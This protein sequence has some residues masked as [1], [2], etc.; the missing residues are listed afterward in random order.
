MN[1][2]ANLYRAGAAALTLTLA[3]TGLYAQSA[4]EPATARETATVTVDFAQSRGAWVHPERYNNIGRANYW[5]PQRDAD[6]RFFNANGLHGNTY[7]IFVI[8]N[9]L[10]DPATGKVDISSVDDWFNDVGRLSDNILMVLD[11]RVQLRDRH[12]TREQIRPFIKK[13]LLELKRKYP[14]I[15]YIEAFNEP[16]YNLA[17]VTT[18]SG[19]YDYYKDVYEIVNEVNRELKPAVP[20]QV[21]G[22]SLMM[23]ND[24]WMRAFLD[25]YKADPSPNKRLDFVSWHEYGEFPPGTAAAGGP[26]AF[27][28]YKTNPSEV[29]AHRIKFNEEMR[30]RGLK[31]DTPSFITETG[32]YPGP[33]SDHPND[34]RPD[35]LIGAAGIPSLHYWMLE[36][37]HNYPFNWVIRHFSEERKDQLIS[38]A[39]VDRKTP[40]TDTFSPYGNA[41][42]M[43]AKLKDERVAAKSNALK[44]GQG[45]YA[46]AT[47]D[48]TGAAVMVWNYQS[49]N[50][51]SFRVNIDMSQL[52]RNL[53]GKRLRQRL[54]RIDER[55]SNYWANPATANLQQVAETVVTPSASH[56][57]SIELTPNALELVVLDPVGG[58]R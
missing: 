26:R 49:I 31:V 33:S 56:R 23:Y 48:R 45:V 57:L 41:M 28:F 5:V 14:K 10:Y 42:A 54:F 39:G 22:P 17:K 12:E 16:D 58:R 43:M 36:S 44:N 8:T 9:D 51:R 37:P 18:P 55:V 46:I 38:R 30:S 21:G 47:K 27:H 11:T 6:I 50:T 3:C 4:H 32:I 35:Y 15:K 24:E 2:A 53:R 19:L 52:P 25:R 40:L 20:L 29:A 7:R 13:V 34:P 1:K